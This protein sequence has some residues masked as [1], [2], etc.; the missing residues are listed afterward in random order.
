[1]DLSNFRVSHETI[2]K[3]SGQVEE[4]RT[5]YDTS[6]LNIQY[7]IDYEATLIKLGQDMDLECSISYYYSTPCSRCL[8]D[9]KTLVEYSTHFIVLD[10]SED[11]VSDDDFMEE[12]VH[13]V[14]DELN[15][16]DLVMSLVITSIPSKVIC[17]EDCKGLC[18]QCGKNLNDD[19]CD[20]H[21]DVKDQRF[22]VLKNLFNE[23]KEV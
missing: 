5:N 7:P 18:P 16:D 8:K 15:M 6:D 22:D 20:C 2:W 13:V 12:V 9:T 4:N 19:S 11:S 17:D 23:H 14:D 10:A 3:F 1:M 21:L